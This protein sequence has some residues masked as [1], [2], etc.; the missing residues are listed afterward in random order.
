MGA[1]C[2]SPER[3]QAF[4]AGQ[5][6]VDEEES[7]GQHLEACAD[8]E[9][10]AA[11]L[12]DDGEARQMASVSR[13]A[14]SIRAGED[15]IDDLRRRLH[16]LG[17]FS[18][19]EDNENFNDNANAVSATAGDGDATRDD[20]RSDHDGSNAAAVYDAPPL[21]R[22]GRYN[23]LRVL[24]TG[25][26]GV[27]YLAE[28][29]RLNR[30]VAIKVAR[31]NV[32]VDPMLRT[33]FF[34]EAEALARFE[35]PHIVPVYEAGE[36]DGL[37]YLV[38]AYCD[39]PTLDDWLAERQAPVEPADAVRLM[40]PLIDA[41][42]HAHSRGILHRDIKPGNIILQKSE[43]RD[44][45]S[46]VGSQKS[47]T[48][49]L[50]SDLR[51]L[52][53]DF[54]PRLTDFGLAKILEARSKE[55]LAGMVLGTAHY[56]APEQAAGHFERVGPATDVYSLGAVLYELLSGRV[57][58][59][60]DSTIDT[61]RRVLI[62]EPPDL[63]RSLK[64]MPEDLG[65]IVH[66]CLIKSPTLRYATAA[67]L[68]DDL[69]RFLAGRQTK[70]RPLAPSER[71]SR[72]CARHP[73][74]WPV[75]G[76]A[77]TALV[78][79]L[80]LL[81]SAQRL[82]RTQHEA[83]K[84]A[85]ELDREKARAESGALFLA[86]QTYANDLAAA[87][88]S[89][90]KGDIPHAIEALRRQQPAEGKPGLRGLEWHYLWA[91]NNQQTQ[92]YDNAGNEIYDLKLSPDGRDLL[93][94]GN[95]SLMRLYNADDLQMRW[96]HQTNQRET[97]GVDYSASG[98]LAATAG[99]DGT[100]RVFD[101]ASGD[102]RLKIQAHADKAFG[103]VFF[104]NDKKLASCGKESV[105]RLWDAE[106]GDELGILEGHNA[107]VEA[108]CVSPKRDLLASAG[109]DKTAMVWNLNSRQLAR[110]L[111][112][113]HRAAIMGVCFSPDGRLIATGGADNKVV[114]WDVKTG[115]RLDGASQLDKIQT[116]AFSA[117]GSRLYVGDRSG[118]VH[119]YRVE[120]SPT[121][122]RRVK[123]NPDPLRSAW[124]AHDTRIWCVIA[125]RDPDTFYTAGEDFYLRRWDRQ[126][127]TKTEPTF[128]D[129]AGD[130]FVDLEFS[131]D[132]TLLFGLRE[133]SGVTVLD[134]TTLRPK[135]PPLRAKHSAWRSLCVLADRDEVAAAN[136][137][138]VVAI[139]NYKTGELRG[140]ITEPGQDFTILG[141]DYSSAAGLLAVSA[142]D[143]NEVRV[144]RAEDCE[145]VSRLPANNHAAIAI[146]PNGRY[147]A[148]DSTDN[149]AVYEIQSR[150][151]IQL[152]AGH[153]ATVNSIAFSPDG[154]MLASGSVDRTVRLWK[155]SGEPIV[156]LTGH[157]AEVTK[158][159]FTPDGRT[160]VSVDERGTAA[161]THV[162]TRQTM[163]EL[164]TPA[165][166]IQGVAISPNSRRMAIIRSL[167]NVHEVVVL[168]PVGE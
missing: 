112:K 132:G 150:Q 157:L 143:F 155:I 59:R 75:L 93:A 126:S 37:Y 29:P 67:E 90:I 47:K 46:E 25:S 159:A 70:A 161:V 115:T 17:L 94:V 45:K 31:G 107:Q 3:M 92:F 91:L 55:T 146:S 106:T 122:E 87:G 30:R 68:A 121:T 168:G 134:A 96:A 81:T 123:L 166:R 33:R 167:R 129:K 152:L 120:R 127:L 20:H 69:R 89:T 14:K 2:L 125:G 137:H 144:Y 36:T 99:D 60:G 11:E 39:G 111:R 42:E 23:I 27:V 21:S 76:L 98:R 79:S 110:P 124:H 128:P 34:R 101:L 50:D 78:L 9:R 28:D 113:E 61:L 13:G 138:G 149:I 84:T 71:L 141:I 148:V 165:E 163:F 164:P 53:S 26:F 142:F 109:A 52:T 49:I 153:Q 48:A 80:G 16:A 114:L 4:L 147:L 73:A 57:P 133:T 43:V 44:Q 97:N 118:S 88:K 140:L 1:T 63:H 160:L 32:L 145:L 72:W 64:N 54:F 135:N 116:V 12:S 130:A 22:L 10:L 8:C 151:Q 95:R 24:G 58:I 119:Q 158:V 86:Q 74:L 117:D 40:L 108:I 100:I 5:L 51:P 139:W 7:A 104:D 6:S 154:G 82:S 18:I 136:A 83:K 156:T 66:K 103:V 19:A 105:I 77:A 162:A 131:P 41:V 85:A 102:E 65:A 38:L 62:D 35:H 15:E 56:M